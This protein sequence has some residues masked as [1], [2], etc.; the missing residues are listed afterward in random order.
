MTMEPEKGIA[1]LADVEAIEEIDHRHRVTQQSTYHQMAEAARRDPSATAI[2]FIARGQDYASPLDISYGQLLGRINQT[3]NLLSE[4]GVGPDDTVTYLLPNIPQAFFTLWG[5]EAVGIANPVNPLLEAAAIADICRAAKT[6]VLVALGEMPGVDIWQKTEAVRD[7][8]PGLEAVLKVM[9]PAEPDRGIYCFDEEVAGRPG[10]RLVF[11]RVFRPEN[12]ASLYHTGGTTGRPKLARRSHMNEMLMAWV[13]AR[14]LGIS[15]G[16]TIMQ[17][18]PLFHCNGTIVTG[19][20]PF[21]VGARVVMLTPAGFRDQAMMANFFRIVEHFRPGY[22]SCVPTVLSALLDLPLDKADISSLKYVLCGAA[23]LSVELFNRFESKT[24]MKILEGYGLTEAAVASAANPRDGE[25]KVGSVGLRLPYHQVQTVVSDDEARIS[26]P[27]RVDEIGTVAIKGPCVFQGYVEQAHN[28]GVWL[29][30]GWFNTGDLGRLDKDGY[31]WLTGR[32]KD[33]IIRGGHNIDPG[34]IEEAMYRHPQVTNAAAV[35]RPD[36]HAGEVPVV[37]VSLSEGAA[38]TPAELLEHAAAQITERAAVPKEVI[39]RDAIPLTAV[40]KVFKPSLRLD[41]M[42]RVCRQ[43]LARL[44]EMKVEWDVR[45]T[46]D[47][48]HGAK[49]VIT[50]NPRPGHTGPEMTTFISELLARYTFHREIV[51]GQPPE[52][53][54]ADKV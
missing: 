12:T 32:A 3:A 8:V 52:A 14:A 24:G 21:S 26:R 23:P 38:V 50:V 39:V 44:D 34:I 9:G 22:F 16:E 43:E 11:D 13:L 1:T 37:Y 47:P 49:A 10:D 33:L 29:D 36:K 19:L 28:Q 5:A 27:A 46:E 25:R 40:G 2:S 41:A 4:L 51:I 48:R 54:G 53:R 35:G 18:L 17:G 30:D 6:K 20:T 42:A 45:V 15:P 31:L 7:Q